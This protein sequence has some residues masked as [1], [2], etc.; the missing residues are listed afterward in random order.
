P[1]RFFHI[2]QPVGSWNSLQ[3]ILE[4]YEA[5]P[6]EFLGNGKGTGPGWKTYARPEATKVFVVVTDDESRMSSN[7]FDR[8]LLAKQPAR[9]FG[10]QLQR[11]YPF[12][13]IGSKPSGAKAPTTER[14]D[15]AS[16]TSV[17]YQ[18]LSLLTGGII[19]EVCKSDYSDVLDRLADGIASK[20]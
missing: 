8:A 15:S 12:H 14:C 10:T 5:A 3:L 17:Q 2:D 11:N 7:E 4:T 6:I 16:G 20:V 13:S 9:A 18:R 19:D 1:P